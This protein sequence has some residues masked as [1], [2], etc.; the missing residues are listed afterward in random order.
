MK[1]IVSLILSSGLLFFSLGCK[2]GEGDP[3]LSLKSRKSR[4]VGEWT[5]DSWT[6][7]MLSNYNS[8]AVSTSSNQGSTYTYTSK[9]T[10]SQT[11]DLKI[12]KTN[13][14][15]SESNFTESFPSS[16]TSSYSDN[17]KKNGT[18][19]GTATIEFSKDG[20]F[21]R[22]IEFSNASFNIIST[23][24]N[25]GAT[26]TNNTSSIES[27]VEITAGTWE[28]L[29][30]IDGDYKNKE[31]VI[32]HIKSIKTNKTYTDISGVV[33]NSSENLSY[34]DADNNEIWLLTT[35]KNNEVVFEAESSYN[36][37]NSKS[38]I[39]NNS[40][41]SLIQTVT[42]NNSGTGAIKGTLSK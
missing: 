5:I 12:D 16:A 6:Y 30:G 36:S 22:K 33:S 26:N 13:F 2:K 20:T 8:N 9:Y 15:I 40:S 31:R 27:K 35:L 19:T 17:E 18:T 42:E 21:T 10:R 41:M 37:T 7:N 25:G 39:L 23:S 34:K 14:T 32:L 38:D 4:L 29:D 3:F 28:F 24:V 1:Y 11:F